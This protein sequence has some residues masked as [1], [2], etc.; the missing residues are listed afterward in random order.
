M[1]AVSRARPPHD[2]NASEANCPGVEA[3]TGRGQSR[4][5]WTDLGHDQREIG[6]L[7]IGVPVTEGVNHLGAVAQLEPEPSTDARAC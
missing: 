4:T 1:R 5:Q 7:Q 2:Q 6:I 3:P